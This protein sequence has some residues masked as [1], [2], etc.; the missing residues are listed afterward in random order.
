MPATTFAS[1]WQCYAAAFFAASIACY[2]HC[3][4]P[5]FTLGMPRRETAH[6]VLIVVGLAFGAVCAVTLELPVPRW[7]VFV[8]GF[9]VVHVPAAAILFV[10]RVGRAGK[11]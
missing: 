5:H 6:A 8:A 7:V 2:A 11:S 10:K 4:T 3:E 1:A 9:G